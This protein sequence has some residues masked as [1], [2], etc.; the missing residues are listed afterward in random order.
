MAATSI[1]G[2]GNQ[3]AVSPRATENCSTLSSESMKPGPALRIEE[4]LQ[5][6][7]E[8]AGVGTWNLM[9][10][11]KLLR[12]SP[13]CREVFGFPA[14][15]EFSYN[16]FLSVIYPDDLPLV[17]K[18]I[19]NAL[20]PRGTGLYEIDYRIARPDGAVRWLGGKGKVFFEERNGEQV[21]IR[22]IGTVLDRTERKK[23]QDALI[24]AERLAVTGRLAASIAH[25][26]RNPV[27]AVVGLLYL[28][29]TEPSEAKRSE[30]LQLAEQEL[31]RVSEIATNT[32]RF[33]QDPA[34]NTSCDLAELAETVPQPVSREDCHLQCDRGSDTAFRRPRPWAA[35]GTAA[36]HRQP[37]KQR[38]GRHAE[39]RPSDPPY[40]EVQ[41]LPDRETLRP[42]DHRRY[43]HRHEPRSPQPGIRGV[44]HNEGYRW[45]WAW[46]LAQPRDYEEMRLVDEGQKRG[47][48]RHRL[49]S[50]AR[51]C[52]IKSFVERIVM[53]KQK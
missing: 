34:G 13:T 28:L 36:S 38:L 11:E 1:D 46:T 25:E 30:Y 21:A 42:A 48:T 20:D 45:K 43:R 39:R 23:I 18:A 17:E 24:E 3:T 53:Q 32:L 47:R 7:A 9:V 29:R 49:S 6:A 51:G 31:S 41:E 52:G 10:E 4:T 5:L 15:A 2:Q 35:R 37:R 44:L 16:D 27:D 22:F 50:L 33:Y 8:T 19:A 40:P 26:I 14:D 12:S